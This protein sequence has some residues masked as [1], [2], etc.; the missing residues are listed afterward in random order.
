MEDFYQK[1]ITLLN[2]YPKSLHLDV[3]Q[4]SKYRLFI[5]FIQIFL[6]H[7]KYHNLFNYFS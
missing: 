4:T 3:P 6:N 2:T 5:F 7:I 1:P